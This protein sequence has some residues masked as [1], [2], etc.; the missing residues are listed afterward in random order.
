[1][2][3]KTDQVQRLRD[4]IARGGALSCT[5]F[6]DKRGVW[7]TGEDDISCRIETQIVSKKLRLAVEMT[8]RIEGPDVTIGVTRTISGPLPAQDFDPEHNKYIFAALAAYRV[9][10]GDV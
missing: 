2:T 3:Q 6:T 5:M 4:K 8:I 9:V 7:L 1:M 10:T